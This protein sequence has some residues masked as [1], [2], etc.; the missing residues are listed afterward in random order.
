[1]MKNLQIKIKYQQQSTTCNLE[2]DGFSEI[3]H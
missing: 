3:N 1:M 2:N